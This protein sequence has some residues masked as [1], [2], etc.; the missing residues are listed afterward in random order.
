MNGRTLFVLPFAFLT[1]TLLAQ[2][3]GCTERDPNHCTNNAGDDY[4]AQQHPDWDQAFCSNNCGE[5]EPDGCVQTQPEDSC[6]ACNGEGDNENCGSI[7]DGDTTDTGTDTTDDEPT[8]TAET[9]TMETTATT[10]T[11]G[12]D[13][14][15]SSECPVGM[16]ICEDGGCVA[17]GD[18]VSVGCGEEYPGTP[19]CDQG[20][21]E[22]VEC[23]EGEAGFCS[24]G[25]PV[26]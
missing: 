2:T 9:D 19:A 13:C 21:G 4:C 14:M 7:G 12:P 26:V 17:C 16:P 1:G 18:A 5:Y 22:C 20:T 6:W 24:G 23:V 11:D 15:D 25:T 10:T 3:S 8:D